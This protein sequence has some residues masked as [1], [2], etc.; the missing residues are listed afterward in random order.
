[1]L[2]CLFMGVMIYTPFPLKIKKFL[3]TPKVIIIGT[4]IINVSMLGS[5]SL[6]TTPYIASFI[7]N[8]LGKSYTW[9]GRLHIYAMIFDVIRTHLWF[10]Y[11]YFSN[12][13]EDILGFGNAQNGV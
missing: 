8:V 3:S 1:M 11:G 13:I 6:L 5:S 10:G 9:V 7:S 12:I 4:A 2:I